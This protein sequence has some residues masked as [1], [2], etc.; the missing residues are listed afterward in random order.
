MGGGGKMTFAVTATLQQGWGWGDEGEGVGWGGEDDVR[1]H[2]H[3]PGE[4]VG[5]AV[6]LQERWGACTGVRCPYLHAPALT[7]M[8]RVEGCGDGALSKWR[9]VSWQ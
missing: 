1:C 7:S 8:G 9:W 4:G 2:S 6:T 5:C 3:A